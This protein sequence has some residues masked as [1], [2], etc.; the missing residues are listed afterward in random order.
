MAFQV[1]FSQRVTPSGV[2]SQFDAGADKVAVCDLDVTLTATIVGD[3]NGHT[4]F[5]EQLSGSPIIITSAQNELTFS[6]TQDTF[7]DKSFRFYIDR[8]SAQEKFD[9][10][11]VFGSPT[12]SA[13]FGFGDVSYKFNSSVTFGKDAL[14][15]REIS[16]F[17]LS[18]TNGIVECEEKLHPTIQYVAESFFYDFQMFL[19]QR[20]DNSTGLWT[21]IRTYT[22]LS[23]VYEVPLPERDYSYRVVGVFDRKNGELGTVASNVMYVGEFHDSSEAGAVDQSAYSFESVSP[24]VYDFFV[25]K[26]SISTKEPDAVSTTGTVYGNSITPNV[27]DFVVEKLSITVKDADIDSVKSVTFQGSDPIISDF[28]VIVRT[29]QAIGDNV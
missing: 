7:D 13:Y 27:Y 11:V 16:P 6:Y 17:T 19:L 29:T 12:S 4:F 26:L 15:L 21:D 9:D 1:I 5:W 28:V 20:R 22:D 8:N 24:N 2:I 25:E 10:V 3:A 18:S 14:T 23:A